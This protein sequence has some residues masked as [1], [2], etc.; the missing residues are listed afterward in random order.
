M[1]LQDKLGSAYVVLCGMRHSDP[2]IED[3]VTQ[4][5]K[6]GA[7]KIVGI[8]LSPQSSSFIMEGYRT[9]LLAAATKSGFPDGSAVIAD[10]WPT[11]K[12]FIELVSRRIEESLKKLE[13]LHGRRP[14]V[15]FTT[16]S[17]PK[18]VVKSDPS[19]LH[20]LKATRDAI[21]AKINNPSLE[22]FTG[23]Q[24]AGHTPE[25]WLK[26]DLVDILK[27]LKKKKAMAVLIAP[28]QFLADHLEILYDLDR[29]GAEQCMEHG[30]AYNRIGLPNIAPLFI[31]ALASIARMRE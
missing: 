4:C 24:S 23:Y 18:R 11:E 17:L 2:S 30:I 8:I 20:Q 14:P 19:Y 3:A 27:M 31:E 15:I 28:I 1:L 9:N 22:W 10:P 12:H 13:H 6:L 25:V 21:V 26:P 29:A 16:H 7:S 5:R